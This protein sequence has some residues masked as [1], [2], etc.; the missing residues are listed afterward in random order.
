MGLELDATK[1]TISP[2]TRLRCIWTVT[3]GVMPGH[4]EA[5]YT[6]R[7]CLTSETWEK[8]SAMTDEAFK[9]IFP[10]GFSTFAK[11]KMAA[12]AYADSLHDPRGL[13]W[14]KLEWMWM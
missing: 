11:Y 6:R 12:I 10:D 9:A 2:G 8:E 14:V 7:W 13:N 1:D 3:A 4:P 5:E